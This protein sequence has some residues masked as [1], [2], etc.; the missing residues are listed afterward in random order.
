MKFQIP[1][2]HHSEVN[3]HTHTHTHTHT[4]KRSKTGSLT[5]CIQNGE[6][7]YIKNIAI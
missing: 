5:H 2:M 3:T 1:N 4:C 7:V 6:V